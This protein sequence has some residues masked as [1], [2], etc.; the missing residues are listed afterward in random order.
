[1]VAEI[2]KSEPTLL[3]VVSLLQS[4]AG[5]LGFTGLAHATVKDSWKNLRAV[6]VASLFAALVAAIQYIPQLTSFAPFLST[7]AALLGALG[8]GA[9]L[10]KK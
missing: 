1:M 8:L 6:S 3:P 2:A 10:A 9:G 5:V 4:I 7:L